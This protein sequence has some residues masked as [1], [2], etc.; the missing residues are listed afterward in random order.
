MN[1]E[2]ECY[3]TE[4]REFLNT[5][6]YLEIDLHYSEHTYQ[7]MEPDLGVGTIIQL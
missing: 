2:A 1:L 7:E 3:F 6:T 4:Y 5:Q